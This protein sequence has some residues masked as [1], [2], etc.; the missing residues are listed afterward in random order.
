MTEPA[1][2]IAL[3]SRGWV[4]ATSWLALAPLLLQLPGLLAATIAVAA[5][6]VGVLSWR[7]TL[8]APVRL[9]LV[10]AMLA[11]VYWQI[12][13]RF[14]RD[15]GCAVLAA[16]LAIKASELR[17]LRDARSLLG[18]ALFAPFAAFLLD[19]GPA[20]MGLALLAVATALLSMQRL[21]D[22]EHRT[23]TPA[24]GLQLRGIGK[25]VA[26]G[27]PLAL[28]TF[29]LLPRLG[30]P[31][32]GV[33]ERALS[34]PGLSDNMS[35]GEWID[36]MADD[37][38]AL[39]VQFA[40]R[41]PPPQQ[42]Y[43]RG[44]VM[45]DFDGRSWQRARWTGRGQPAAV[46]PGPQTYRYRLDYE[47]TDRRQ[48]VSLDL[49]TSNVA[50]AELSPDYELFAQRPLT[51]LTRWE[52]QSAPP[53]RFDTD[54]PDRLRAR[55][56]A[57]PPGFNPRTLA[58]ARQWRAEAGNDDGA[59]VQRALQW[60]T[61]EF[62]YTLDTPLLGRNSV[63]E[64][65]FQQKA[66]FCEHFSSSFVVLMRG[67]GI[68]AR[69]V[70][71]YTGGVYNGLGN[72]WV[73][74]R[75]DAHAWAEVWLAGRGWVRVD[76]TAAVAPE[77]IYDTLED[78][79]Q[80]GG[81][82]D[83][84]QLGTWAG[85][86]QVSDW[87]RRGWN[88]LVLSFD[89]ERQQRLLQPFGIDRLDTSQLTLIFGIFAGGALAWMGWLLARGERERDPLLRAWHRVGR[90]YRKLGLAREPHEPAT[91]WAQRVAHEHPGTPLLALSQR[92]AAARYAGASLDSATLLKDLQQHRPRTGDSS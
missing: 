29:W 71:G 27:V 18:F 11:A 1:A 72:Y 8:M 26:I 28:V 22:E 69:V 5:V 38:P 48:L 73:V 53:A 74:R 65:L 91:V 14:G 32:W 79:L 7:G 59:V 50:N 34:R 9:L 90:R 47:P 40:G 81:G 2:P 52:L 63:D 62:A 85:L 41:A 89:A 67:A 12:G 92:F 42:R 24:L 80:A 88:E 75:M 6:L 54:L 84:A 35:P 43:W 17:T 55:A 87:L 36:L 86:G 46:V 37:N 39:R 64:F 70:T 10:V 45:W 51:A 49:P 78:R 82:N 15:T 3:A 30:A 76:P 83:F 77:R 23:S 21:A 4:L 58:L 56:L 16:M 31:L 25:L 68:P 19:Q 60:I 66:G 13:M 33:P 44:P 57:L 20:T 61:R